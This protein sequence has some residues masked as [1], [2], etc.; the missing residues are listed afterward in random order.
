MKPEHEKV[1]EK[2][3]PA[4]IKQ[5]SG[6]DAEAKSSKGAQ[7][8]TQLMP[9]TGREWAKKLG[10]EKYDPY[11]AEQNEHIG[12]EYLG[13]LLEQFNGDAKLALAA[14]NHGIGNVKEKMAKWGKSYKSIYPRLPAET[15]AY[16]A[17]ISKRADIA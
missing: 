7:G 12:R 11:D 2:I 9:A 14:Y 1:V 6:G 3:M 4:L 17:R 16:V 13:W 10:Y 8:L 15:Q 5:E